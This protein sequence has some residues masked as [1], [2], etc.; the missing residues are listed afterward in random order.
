MTHVE[1]APFETGEGVDE[2]A[3]IAASDEFQKNFVSQQPGFIKRELL[4]GA[5]GHWVD[6]IYWQSKHDAEQVMQSAGDNE[7]VRKF[8]QLMKAADPENP[9]QGVSHF[10]HKKTYE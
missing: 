5:D 8:F 10:E 4:K 9:G 6:L 7:A 3:L 1:W 2:A